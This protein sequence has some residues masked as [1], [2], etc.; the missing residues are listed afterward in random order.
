MKKLI[1]I[2]ALIFTS[3]GVIQP[4]EVTEDG[5]FL[6]KVTE[7]G[8]YIGRCQDN[9]TVI[10]WDV[11]EHISYRAFRTDETGEIEFKVRRPG[12]GRRFVP[13]GSKETP[14]DIPSQVYE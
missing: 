7:E 1:F 9:R 14:E 6:W 12:T 10:Q 2:L 4:P 8:Y 13:L 3:C 5:C 11:S